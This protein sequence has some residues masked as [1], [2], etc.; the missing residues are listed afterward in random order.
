M[1][2]HLQIY[3]KTTHKQKQTA[4]TCW[5]LWSL[6]KMACSIELNVGENPN[7][8]KFYINNSEQETD[9]NAQGDSRE[10][11]RA[12]ETLLGMSLIRL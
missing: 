9:D 12:I 3:A 1:A 4:K 2:M 10:T 11:Q 7:V 8:L 5:L 6:R